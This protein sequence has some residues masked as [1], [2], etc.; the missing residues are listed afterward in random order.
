MRTI[1][2]L[3]HEPE[4][5]KLRLVTMDTPRKQSLVR[6]DQGSIR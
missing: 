2:R 6:Y 3:E 5:P 4:V 1:N